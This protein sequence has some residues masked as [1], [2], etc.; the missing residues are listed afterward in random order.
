MALPRR[1]E[2]IVFDMDGLIFDT[3]ATYRAA[4]MATAADMGH[5]LPEHFFLALIG[6]PSDVARPLW[7]AE[8]GT[9]FDIDA[10]LK[11]ARSRF[12]ARVEA[13]DLLK[14]GVVARTGVQRNVD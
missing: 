3:E 5:P 1:P 14:P 6:L 4:I 7:R 13:G 12:H 10:F 2:G 8:F 9:G 11:E